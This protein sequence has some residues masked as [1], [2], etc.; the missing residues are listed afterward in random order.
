M[1]V[2]QIY[3]EEV[4]GD[5]FYGRKNGESA[6]DVLIQVFRDAMLRKYFMA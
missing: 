1:R 4:T 3:R 2:K 5:L 6:N